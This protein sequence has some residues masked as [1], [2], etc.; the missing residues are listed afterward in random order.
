M[1]LIPARH[2]LAFLAVATPAVA[3]N[4]AF[5]LS[6]SASQ[7]ESSGGS[8]SPA[9]G[10]MLDLHDLQQLAANHNPTLL[11]A[12]LHVKA[13]RA[14]ARQAGLWPN[15]SVGVISEPLPFAGVKGEFT[16][17]TIQQQIVTG[18]KLSLSRQKYHARAATAGHLL[19][20]QQVRVR[21][22]VRI[23]YYSVLAK[24]EQL[25]VYK[26]LLRNAED[27]N[28]TVVELVNLGQADSGEL[29]ES[30]ARLELSKL[31]YQMARNQYRATVRELGAVVGVDLS[32]TEVIGELEGELRIIEFEEAMNRILGESPQLAAARSEVETNKLEVRRE[33]REPY[34]TIT[35]A[36]GIG[37][38]HAEA[39]WAGAPSAYRFEAATQIPLFDRNHGTVDQAKEELRRQENEVRRLELALR[40]ELAHHY[41]TYLSALQHVRGYSAVVLPEYRTAYQKRLDAYR[42]GRDDWLHVLD[43]QVKYYHERL[44]YYDH[45]KRWREEEALIDGMLLGDGLESPEGAIPSGHADATAKPR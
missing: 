38:S 32:D 29:N 11:Q 45:L 6:A 20:M 27:R 19:E 39:P 9:A 22:E 18:G 2:A 4:V 30:N 25:E 23:E 36:M 41:T 7:G 13:E 14:R 3:E 8:Q 26:A 42:E 31:D 16:G 21:T 24:A 10:R 17:F 37:R 15:P 1:K 5:N 40:R 33:R 28:A 34:P 44:D 43:T 12:R 35:I